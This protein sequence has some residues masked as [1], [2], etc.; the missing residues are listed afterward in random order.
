MCRRLL[1][2]FLPSARNQHGLFDFTLSVSLRRRRLAP[3]LSASFTTPTARAPFVSSVAAATRTTLAD[4]MI[5]LTDGVWACRP[6]WGPPSRD[7]VR[8]AARLSRSAPPTLTSVTFGVST[9]RLPV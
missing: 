8:W 5:A 9:T 2:P 6:P 1:P 4:L 3:F 7:S